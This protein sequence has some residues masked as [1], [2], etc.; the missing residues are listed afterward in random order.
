MPGAQDAAADVVSH[1]RES[2]GL[3]YATPAHLRRPAKG[4]GGETGPVRPMSAK[5]VPGCGLQPLRPGA[6]AMTANEGG[7]RAAGT[8]QRRGGGGGEG[9]VYLSIVLGA[10]NDGHE[11]SFMTR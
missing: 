5:L 8:G 6:K 4:R 2:T 7:G 9:E 11:G 3:L 10:R 1:S